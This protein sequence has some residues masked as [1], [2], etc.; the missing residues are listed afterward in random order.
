M[1][2]SGSSSE[3]HPRKVRSKAR[4]RSGT[5]DAEPQVTEEDVEPL[6]RAQIRALQCRLR[7]S[8]DPT[9]YMLASEFS[10]RFILYYNVSDDVYA[11]NDP[12]GGTLFKRLK[13]AQAVRS[14]LVKEPRS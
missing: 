3:P 4:M 13:T 12:T 2:I 14:C 11:M 1:Q 10:R 7:D 6:S 8:Q 5:K 9:R